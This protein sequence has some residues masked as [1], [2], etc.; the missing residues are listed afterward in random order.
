M[1]I[2]WHYVVVF[3]N[4]SV[5]FHGHD[6][7][8]ASLLRFHAALTGGGGLH[9]EVGW[10]VSTPGGS[11]SPPNTEEGGIFFSL[12]LSFPLENNALGGSWLVWR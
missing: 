10:Y 4:L 1:Y 8:N 9:T 12:L 3:V 7:E 5:W 2:Q 6:V 11:F